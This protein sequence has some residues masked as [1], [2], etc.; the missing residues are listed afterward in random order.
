MKYR[1]A[2]YEKF[3]KAVEVLKIK[4]LELKKLGGDEVVV[5][6]KASGINPSDVK[7]RAGLRGQLA[8]PYQIPHNDGAGVIIDK[9]KNVKDLCIGD[10]V[11]LYNAALERCNGTAA[12]YCILPSNLC[13][14]L[15]EKNDFVEGACLGVPALTAASSLLSLDQSRGATILVTGGAGAVGNMAIQLAKFLGF[16]VI[17]TASNIEKEEKSLSAGAD[18][19][20]N[21]KEKDL[22]EKIFEFTNGKQL[23][24]LID[25]DFGLNI[26]W[27]LKVLKDYSTIATYSSAG[28]PYPKIDFYEMMFKGITIKTIFVYKLPR[29]LRM[30][31]IELVQDS[32]IKGYLKPLIYKTFHLDKICEAHELVEKGDKIGQ[33][34]LTF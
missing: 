5:Q 28:N 30:K 34:V 20:I 9:G 32:L 6:I 13:Q 7:I 8:F 29:K 14:I 25:V 12:E 27:S 17:T 22:V 23:D 4:E 33:V 18:L 26:K 2:Y 19:V 10:R 11:W 16:K 24:G 1:A 21:Y 31:S 3:G 15:P